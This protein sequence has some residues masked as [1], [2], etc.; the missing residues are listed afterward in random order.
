MFTLVMA[1]LISG[2]PLGAQVLKG[3]LMQFGAELEEASW[4]TGGNWLQ[5]YRRIV[6]PLLAPTLLVVA[7]IAFI[8]AARNIS[9]VALLSNSANRPLSMLQLDYMA[10]GK[11]EL[12]SVVACVIL[13][14]TVGLALLARIFGYKGG[15]GS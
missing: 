13:F 8:G 5:T 4:L 1:G 15:L 7:L 6:L 14:L 11:F 3:N 2:L 9:Q 10:Q 12:A